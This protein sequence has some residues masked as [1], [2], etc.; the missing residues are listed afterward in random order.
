[1][2]KVV[3]YLIVLILSKQIKDKIVKKLIKDNLISINYLKA[4]YI[5]YKLIAISIKMKHPRIDKDSAKI[6]LGV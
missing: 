6:Q 5:C 4:N 1:M 3:D 2:L